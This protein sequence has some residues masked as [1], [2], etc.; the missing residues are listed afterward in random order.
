M[1]QYTDFDNGFAL[2]WDNYFAVIDR[3]LYPHEPAIELGEGVA[4]FRDGYDATVRING[5]DFDQ[6]SSINI[7][8]KTP[9][10]Q[11]VFVEKTISWSEAVMVGD[12]EVDVP[13]HNTYVAIAPWLEQWLIGNVGE[14]HV[15][16]DMRSRDSIRNSGIFFREKDDAVAFINFVNSFLKGIKISED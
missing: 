7:D 3:P 6:M 1:T 5:Y 8:I 10:Q 11:L 13:Y 12:K 16:W 14:K 15:A 9:A 4:D 2:S